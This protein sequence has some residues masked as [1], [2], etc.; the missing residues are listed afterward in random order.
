MNIKQL[1]LITMILICSTNTYNMVKENIIN[2]HD[3]DTFL[4]IPQDIWLHL[5][6]CCQSKSTLHA[7]CTYFYKLIQDN[8]KIILAHHFLVLNKEALDKFALYH[9]AFGDTAIVSNL[10]QKGANP[11]THHEDNGMRLISYAIRYTDTD[12]LNVLLE[13]SVHLSKKDQLN[14]KTEG[15]CYASE[16]GLCSAVQKL[17]IGTVDINAYNHQGKTPLFIATEQGNIRIMKLLLSNGASPYTGY[18]YPEE[19]NGHPYESFESPIN[20]AIQHG[21]TIAV[22]LLIEYGAFYAGTIVSACERSKIETVKL[23][24]SK[25]DSPY[26]AEHN[27]PTINELIQTHNAQFE[28]DK[29]KQ[30]ENDNCVVQ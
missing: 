17:L 14:M 19:W 15:L 13:H 10:L 3:Q 2:V 24:L 11:N 1:L 5:I 20:I 30:K 29:K 9:G 12:M 23:L 21:H 16:K 26:F 22:Q 4:A 7:T 6:A 25:R 28:Q 27:N 18:L 8:K